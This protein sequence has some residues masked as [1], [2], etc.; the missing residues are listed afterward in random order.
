MYKCCSY[1]YTIGNTGLMQTKTSLHLKKSSSFFS[2]NKNLYGPR[3]LLCY[4]DEDSATFVVDSRHLRYRKF[5][6]DFI[7]ILISFEILSFNKV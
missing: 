2:N 6:Y 5:V 1:I 4:N 3:L 7:T